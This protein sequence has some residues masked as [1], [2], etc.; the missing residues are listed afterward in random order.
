MKFHKEK[1]GSV[2]GCASQTKILPLDEGK[3]TFPSIQ[4]WR[5]HTCVLLWAPK[6]KSGTGESS[7]KGD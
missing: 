7:A 6:Y 1:D 2:L 4:H 3:W 5:D